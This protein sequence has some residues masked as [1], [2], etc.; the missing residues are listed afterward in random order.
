MQT[1]QST[2]PHGRRTMMFCLMDSDGRTKAH[3]KISKKKLAIRDM[4]EGRGADPSIWPSSNAIRDF[5]TPHIGIRA[6]GGDN[7]CLPVCRCG[8]G[9]ASAVSAS[10]KLSIRSGEIFAASRRRAEA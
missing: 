9:E 3:P 2:S 10:L 1:T 4:R 7:R 5:L 6:L 8:T